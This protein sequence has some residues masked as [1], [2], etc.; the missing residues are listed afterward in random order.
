MSQT[1]SL[2]LPSGNKVTF[3]VNAPADM[4]WA[5]LKGLIERLKELH[6]NGTRLR[7]AA[8][9]WKEE[10]QRNQRL[11]AELVADKDRIDFLER[12]IV[13]ECCG[14]RELWPIGPEIEYAEDENTVVRVY[15]WVFGPA[16]GRYATF[17]EA[18]DAGRA[19]HDRASLTL[20]P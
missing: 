11:V 16:D 1:M 20:P 4:A 18:I 2:V 17:R 19:A 14:S 13:D 3:M 5:E 15:D 7:E 8:D 6:D 9:S 10:A 12:Y